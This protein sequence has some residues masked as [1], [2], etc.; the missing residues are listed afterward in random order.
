M[1]QLVKNPPAM[2][3]TQVWSLGWEDPLEKGK[4]NHSSI[5]AWRIPW[6]KSKGSQRVTQDWANFTHLKI[7]NYINFENWNLERQNLHFWDFAVHYAC[8]VGEGN[9][10]PLQYSSLENPVD[11]EPDGLLSIGSYRVGLQLK[12]LSMHACIWEGTGNPLQYSCLENPRDRGAWWAAVYGVTQRWT[13]LK[14]LSSSSSSMPLLFRSVAQSCLTLCNPVNRST[15]GLPVHHQLP[16]STQT[17]VHWVADTIQP[18][19]SLLSPTPPAL[20]LSQHQGI[21]KWVSSSHQVAKV[22]EF[23]L[24]HHIFHWTPRTDLL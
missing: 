9:G 10:N 24:Q 7:E 14:Q 5:L 13:L 17:H 3:E 21:F 22:L 8:L 11:E 16:E 2:Q 15:P 19:H 6:I 18:S 4:A 12:Q 20:N 1:A 23:Q